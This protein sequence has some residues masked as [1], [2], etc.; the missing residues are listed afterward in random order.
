MT[1]LM[2]HLAQLSAKQGARRFE[3]PI[4]HQKRIVI[5]SFL[6]CLPILL[7]VLNMTYSL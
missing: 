7:L 6:G 1:G 3:Q 5:F 2:S 4:I